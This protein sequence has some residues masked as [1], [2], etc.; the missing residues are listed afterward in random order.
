MQTNQILQ[1]DCLD[2]F[3]Q[4]PDESIQ[5]VFSD[6]PFN[7]DKKYNS[8][9]DNKS[10]EE[11]LEWCKKWLSEMVRVSKGSIFIHNIPKWLTYYTAYLNTFPELEFKHWIALDFSSSPMGK[12]LQPAHYGILYYAKEKSKFYE[13][14]V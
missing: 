2:L 14:V 10:K 13:S 12:S 4:I 5:V 6:P 1:G 3:K 9:E 8:Y 7:L 11:Y